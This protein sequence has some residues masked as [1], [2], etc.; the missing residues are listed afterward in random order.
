M[1]K[2]STSTISKIVALGLAT[3][4]ITLMSAQAASAATLSVNFTPLNGFFT[5]GTAPDSQP[6]VSGIFR[7]DLSGINDITSILIADGNGQTG[8]PGQ[9]SGFDLDAIKI[10]TTLI[11]NAVDI[12]TATPLNVF[13]ANPVFTPGTQRAP[14]DPALFG[15]TGGN[16]N[17]AVATLNTVDAF[18]FAT[19]PQQAGGFVSL[20]DGGQVLFNLT[21]ALPSGP[22]YLYVGE[23]GNNL[24]TLAPVVVTFD[25]PT[26]PPPTS[27]PEPG[28][29][30]ALS[31]MGIY[32][33]ARR[34]QTAKTA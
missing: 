23:A 4:A 17:N 1:I 14:V 6:T 22:L 20:G 31:L 33:A 2:N 26:P 28:S 11:N 24:E 19:T 32:F 21:S 34:K 13:A 16:I 27:V 29:L 7:A 3:S 10:S 9:F 8:L 30:A 25:D 5:T 18:V 12:N 15:T